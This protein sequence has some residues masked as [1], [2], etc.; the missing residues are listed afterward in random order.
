VI[1]FAK[2]RL[3][4]HPDDVLFSM[5][6]RTTPELR[7]EMER[8]IR[9]TVDE[10]LDEHD[11]KRL[12]AS[13]NEMLDAV[14]EDLWMAANHGSVLVASFKKEARIICDR[15]WRT[16]HGAD[17]YFIPTDPSRMDRYFSPA[18]EE[19]EGMG[20]DQYEVEVERLVRYID[21]LD[22]DCQMRVLMEYLG[23]SISR[24]HWFM[25]DKDN[26]D[27]SR[28]NYDCREKLWNMEQ[29]EQQ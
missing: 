26:K 24:I 8:R 20:R 9:P 27:T 5:L 7:R 23:H 3:K 21:R 18:D 6:I 16:E 12:H 2:D 25:G 1:S 14:I 29:D 11:R 17:R 22:P 10:F 28:R 19:L 13:T 4:E 15:H